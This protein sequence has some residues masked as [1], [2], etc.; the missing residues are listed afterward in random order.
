MIRHFRA[1]IRNGAVVACHDAFL[2][3]NFMGF[4]ASHIGYIH[5]GSIFGIGDMNHCTVK[6]NINVLAFTIDFR[7]I[8]LTSTAT[9]VKLPFTSIAEIFPFNVFIFLR[10]DSRNSA[11]PHSRVRR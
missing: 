1:E 6:A 3:S 11:G 2:A 7:I 10:P 4:T 5:V 8:S 9:E